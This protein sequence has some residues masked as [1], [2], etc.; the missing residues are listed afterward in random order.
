MS[1]HTL[2]AG[3]LA[4]I[5]ANSW[6]VELPP[7]PQWP[8]IVFDIDS[9][10]EKAWCLGG[11]YDQHS[12]NIV[13]LSESID[14]FDTVFPVVRAAFEQLPEYLEDEDFGDADY[15]PDPKVYARFLAFRL[16]T[17]RTP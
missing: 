5:L 14:W 7:D 9:V 6:A 11:G 1:V 12:V 2:V 17:R 4:P 16:R 8:A 3:V 15:E 13:F 10:P